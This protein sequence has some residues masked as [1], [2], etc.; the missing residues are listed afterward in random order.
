VKDLSGLKAALVLLSA[1]ALS[2]CS[3]LFHSNARPEQVYYLRAPAAGGAKAPSGGTEAPGGGTEAPGGAGSPPA[4][5]S[6]ASLR[7]THPLA[8][9]GLDSQ[10]IM[11]VQNDHRMNF[12]A[13]SRW[14]SAV[15]DVIESLVV[16]TLRAS[17][18]WASVEDTASPFPSDYLLQTAIRRFEADYTGGAAAPVVYVV[19]DCLVGRGEGR[20]VIANF[21]ASGSASAAA[22]RL[23]EVVT[24][25]EQASGTAL[26]SLASQTAQAVRGDEQRR[27]HATRNPASSGGPG[28]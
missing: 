21:S 27:A 18:A 3:G 20:E 13:G 26:D 2:G 15:P 7:V 1:A 8:S 4:L 6:P 22:N 17:G 10:R 11:L 28:R 23:S 16:Q 12:Y 5:A 19:I 14:P 9:P 24:A 25:F